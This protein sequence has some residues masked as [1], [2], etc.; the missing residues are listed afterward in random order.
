MLLLLQKSRSFSPHACSVDAASRL[1]PKYEESLK[2]SVAS[3][4]ISW[5]YSNLS[6]HI[7]SVCFD[8]NADLLCIGGSITQIR[9]AATGTLHCWT[10]VAPG[11][12]CVSITGLSQRCDTSSSQP[13]LSSPSAK[14][15]GLTVRG[16]GVAS[17]CVCAIAPSSPSLQTGAAFPVTFICFSRYRHKSVN[18]E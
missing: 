3:S 4:E 9:S 10:R 18:V 1:R 12:C 8:V 15:R 17:F 7:S 13:V 2:L 11:E 14:F 5:T 6:E 16:R